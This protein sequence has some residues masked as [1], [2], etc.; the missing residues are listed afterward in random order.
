VLGGPIVSLLFEHGQFDAAASA[1]TGRAL[2]GYSL[3]IP[4]VGM[5]MLLT[6]ALYACGEVRAPV[7]I[8]LWCVAL[9]IALDLALV[10]PLGEL[11]LALAT[12]AST[13]VN[14]WLL[15]AAFRARMELPRGER[16]MNGLLPA[17]LL[18]LLMGAVVWVVDAGVAR[19]V[20]AAGWPAG[21]L[22]TLGLRTGAGMGAGLA[23]YLGLAGR[24]CPQE[25]TELAR[26]WRRRRPAA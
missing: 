1:L 25:W 7:R 9:N 2:L 26:L 24:L 11:G 16:I 15:L 18:T 8:G 4:C 23:V 14:A 21:G 19:G 10:G 17:V 3:G 5:V 6:R 12:S 13:A 22:L 20:A